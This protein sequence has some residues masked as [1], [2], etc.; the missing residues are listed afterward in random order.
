MPVFRRD[1]RSFLFVH[2]PKAGGSALERVFA[3]SGWKTHYRD[4]KEAGPSVN[5][6]R[7]CSPQHMH[8]TMLETLFRM[9]R[10]DGVF[11]TVREPF[12]RFRSEYAMRNQ[13]AVTA[14]PEHVDEWAE[15]AFLRYAENPFVFDNHLRPQSEFYVPGC[16]VYRLEDGLEGVVRD[17]NARWDL[18]LVE[19]VPR[20]MDRQVASGSASSEVRVSATL[21]ARLRACYSEDLSRFGY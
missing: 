1:G 11:M 5:K 13:S 16:R 14:D 6:L 7:R 4:P 19:E 18:G 12:A 3:T 2:V 8:R 15:R 9:E 20:V 17:L 10:F 21:E